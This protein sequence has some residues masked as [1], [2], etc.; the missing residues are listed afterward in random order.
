MLPLQQRPMPHLL[1][2]PTP[3]RGR[4]RPNSSSS[5]RRGQTSGRR[6]SW[7]VPEP[8]HPVQLRDTRVAIKA[9]RTVSWRVPALL[10]RLLSLAHLTPSSTSRDSRDSHLRNGGRPNR[11]SSDG[12]RRRLRRRSED[13]KRTGFPYRRYLCQTRDPCLRCRRRSPR[14]RHLLLLAML[15]CP[16]YRTVTLIHHLIRF[17]PLHRTEILFRKYQTV[18]C[19][20]HLNHNLRFRC[21]LR[22]RTNLHQV[23]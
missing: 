12:E 10:P 3:L 16:P 1:K 11:Q 13:R 2:I 23:P 7:T 15:P 18:A 19:Y 14:K 8:Q 20:P 9:T 22:L 4:R 5:S 17:L 6:L 21:P